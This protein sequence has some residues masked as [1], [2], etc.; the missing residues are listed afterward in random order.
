M[1]Y[2][3]LKH[4]NVGNKIE[5]YSTWEFENCNFQY[6]FLN[7]IISVI[8]G[9][10]FTKFETPLVEGHSE[11]TMSQIFDIGPIFSFMKS[12]KLSCKK[13]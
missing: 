6:F 1:L 9:A 12:R 13:L 10:K 8:N 3:D 7:L 11:G 5:V 4:V 2:S